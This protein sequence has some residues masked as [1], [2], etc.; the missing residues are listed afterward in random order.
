MRSHD[1]VRVFY[2]LFLHPSDQLSRQIKSNQVIAWAWSSGVS[3]AIIMVL[4]K[5]DICCFLFFIFLSSA[6]APARL[7]LWWQRWL[8]LLVELSWVGFKF[9]TTYQVIADMTADSTR[10]GST[11]LHSTR[12]ECSQGW[13]STFERRS[14]CIWQYWLETNGHSLWSGLVWCNE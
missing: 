4:I 5:L 8:G 11:P 13:L 10:L 12:L 1:W 2:K 7:L 3:V 9:L 14:P 6:P